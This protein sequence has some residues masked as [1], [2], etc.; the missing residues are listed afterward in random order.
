MF[1]AFDNKQFDTLRWFAEDV[2]GVEEIECRWIRGRQG[3]DE[4]FQKLVPV[5][6]DIH[7][8]MTDVHENIWGEVGLLTCSIDQR[9]TLEGEPQHIS[10]PATMVFRHDD[11]AWKA[12]LFH[13]I[14]LPEQ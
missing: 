13:M 8:D 9:Y 4:Y 10:C 2:Q 3:L 7:T 6:D 11:A 12:V 1:E 14:P 5:I